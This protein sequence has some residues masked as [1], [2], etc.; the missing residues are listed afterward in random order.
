MQQKMDGCGRDMVAAPGISMRPPAATAPSTNTAPKRCGASR[1]SS[2][3]SVSSS[4]RL[5]MAKDKSEFDQ[6]MAERRN[7]PSPDQPQS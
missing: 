4:T 7:R 3:N 2:A 1:T 6:F 5:R